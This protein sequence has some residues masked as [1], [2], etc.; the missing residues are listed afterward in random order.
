VIELI[1]AKASDRVARVIVERRGDRERRR[2]HRPPVII[3]QAWRPERGIGDLYRI[4]CDNVAIA[5][6]LLGLPRA[7]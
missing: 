1:T 4:A 3:E 2:G 7:D 5:R 6:G